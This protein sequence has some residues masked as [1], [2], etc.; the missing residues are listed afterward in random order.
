[1]PSSFR[2]FTSS[3]MRSISRA[4]FT[5]NG[6]SLTMIDERPDFSCVS[7]AARA[8]MVSTPRPS[9]YASRMAFRP[10]MKP[11]VGKSGPGMNRISSSTVSSGFSISATRASQTSPRLCGGMFVAIPTAMPADPLTSRFGILLGRT[12][13]SS[14]ESS[15]FGTKP[16]VSLSMSA[17]SSSA[18][19]VSRHSV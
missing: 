2:S 4:L 16:T 9:R 3:A 10:Q 13:G 1:M 5:W 6:I 11:P 12:R 19:S 17:S 15:K 8:R 14:V 7:T 18:S